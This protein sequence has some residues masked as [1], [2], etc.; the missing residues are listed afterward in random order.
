MGKLWGINRPLMSAKY[1]TYDAKFKTYDNKFKTYDAKSH[2]YK[3]KFGPSHEGLW[4]FAVLKIA[5]IYLIINDLSKHMN[6]EG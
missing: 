4:M 1:K 2:T 6:V 5:F 3:A